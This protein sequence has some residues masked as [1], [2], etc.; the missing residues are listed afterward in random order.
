MRPSCASIAGRPSRASIAG[1]ASAAPAA[2]V[3]SAATA[4]ADSAL[5]IPRQAAAL[6]QNYSWTRKKEQPCVLIVIHNVA[7][8]L[9]LK[10]MCQEEGCVVHTSETGLAAL[11]I[12][13]ANGGMYTLCLID[14]VL[15]DIEPQSLC[16]QMS[17]LVRGGA[18][19]QTNVYPLVVLNP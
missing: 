5:T 3:A 18:A 7:E 19:N 2:S 6:Q 16:S 10:R 11:Q 9:L 17:E 13:A 1:P 14:A 8:R 12:L 4:L 15:P